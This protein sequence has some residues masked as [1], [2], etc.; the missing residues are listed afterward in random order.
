MPRPSISPPKIYADTSVFG[1]VFD[2]EFARASKEFFKSIK[3]GDAQLITSAVVEDELASAPNR[4]Q[5]YFR[6]MLPWMHRALLS[7]DALSLRAAYINAGIVT[8]RSAADALHVAIATTNRCSVL[9]SWNCRH[10]VHFQKIPR[11][12]EINCSHG[13]ANIAIHTPLEVIDGEN[14]NI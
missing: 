5:G 10:I 1:G 7:E 12:N 9:I 4:V 2:Q 13:F 11:Y 8:E 3:R 6:N 14:E